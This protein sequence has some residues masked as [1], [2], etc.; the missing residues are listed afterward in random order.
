MRD[1]TIVNLI[2]IKRVFVND[3]DE[4]LK[5]IFIELPNDRF[6]M[7]DNK[8]FEDVITQVNKIRQKQNE[9]DSP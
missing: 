7:F 9:Q 2:D 5:G 8:A 6:I 1:L 3:N 4:G